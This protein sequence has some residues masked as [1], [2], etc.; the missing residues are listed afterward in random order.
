MLDVLFLPNLHMCHDC[1]ALST[2]GPD[3][4]SLT[5]S[6]GDTSAVSLTSEGC[7]PGIE[8]IGPTFFRE[9]LIIT[10]DWSILTWF[11]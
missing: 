2:I 7:I 5:D 11:P 4:L 9:Q 3:N 1:T 10:M 8:I 6:L